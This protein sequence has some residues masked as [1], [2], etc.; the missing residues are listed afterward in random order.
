VTLLPLLMATML[1]LHDGQHDF[2]FEIGTW[3]IAARSLLHPLSGSHEWADRNNYRHIVRKVWGG[4][5][6]LAELEVMGATPSYRGLMLRLYDATTAR[7]SVYWVSSADNK[8]SPPLVGDFQ[9]GRGEFFSNDTYDGKP[10]EV[11][12]VY[13]QITA[14][15][16]HTEQA[17]SADG[18]KTW[19]TNLIQDFTRLST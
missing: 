15:S 13:S 1:A 5:A 16:F 3:S 2:D 4:Q 18:G 17:F 12:V 10:I 7:W 11:R 19:E 9:N 14:T 8:I 6:S